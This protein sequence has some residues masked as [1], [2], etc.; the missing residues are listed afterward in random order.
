MTGRERNWLEF[1]ERAVLISDK[2]ARGNSLDWTEKV[3]MAIAKDCL[4]QG[5][6]G[7]YLSNFERKIYTEAFDGF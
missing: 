3:T 4:N 1:Y 5:M 2:L 7:E 6:G